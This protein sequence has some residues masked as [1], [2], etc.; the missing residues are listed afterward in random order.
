MCPV[1]LY[2]HLVLGTQMN[3]FSFFFILWDTYQELI[4]FRAYATYFGTFLNAY[5]ECEDL[6]YFLPSYCVLIEL[7]CSFSCLFLPFPIELVKRR[8][9]DGTTDI[10][11]SVPVICAVDG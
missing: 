5:L 2:H 9:T 10:P 6:A 1:Y 11:Y 8:F 7:I 3:T 4:A